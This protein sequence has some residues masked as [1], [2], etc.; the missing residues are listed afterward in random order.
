MVPVRWNLQRDDNGRVST[1]WRATSGS[2]FD[3]GRVVDEEYLKYE[4][5]DD[6][7]AHAS[8][9]GEAR[10][11]IHLADRLLTF[12]SVLELHSDVTSLHYRYRRELHKDG[13]L[14]RERSWQRRFRRTGH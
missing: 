9:R 12:S 6:D 10:T 13:L 4:V 14:V 3:W 2:E 11:D 1:W 5:S 8:A 7:P